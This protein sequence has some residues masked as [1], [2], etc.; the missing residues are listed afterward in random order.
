[1]GAATTRLSDLKVKAAK[2]KE[3]D[4]TLSKRVRLVYDHLKQAFSNPE[5]F[6]QGLGT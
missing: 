5:L 6:P 4:Y 3:K 1:M 2:P